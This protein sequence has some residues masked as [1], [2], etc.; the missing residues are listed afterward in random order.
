M[1][2][3]SRNRK[4]DTPDDGLVEKV[5]HIKDHDG[6]IVYSIMPHGAPLALAP[7][8]M[9]TKVE[10][11]TT[12]EEANLPRFMMH[13][14]KGSGQ[15]KLAVLERCT[16]RGPSNDGGL[17]REVLVSAGTFKLYSYTPSFEGQESTKTDRDGEPL[18][19]YATMPD[20]SNDSQL[21]AEFR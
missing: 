16:K 10:K 4:K 13:F 11:R 5:I 2:R 15:E 20:A 14:T 17:L 3:M 21:M 18:F 6:K 8:A 1:A 19:P 7:H 12:V 9:G